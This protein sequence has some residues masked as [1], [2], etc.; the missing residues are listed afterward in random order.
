MKNDCYYMHLEKINLFYSYY[1][2]FDVPEFFADQLFIQHQVRVH[3]Y[4]EYQKKGKQYV[5][6]LC[7]VRKKDEERFLEA[8][9][10]LPRKMLLLGYINYL[11]DCSELLEH[12]EKHQKSTRS[13]S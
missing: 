3:F 4:G 2:Y 11:E 7:R 6:V 1:A 10:E 8:L 9:S 5:V 12:I 13:V